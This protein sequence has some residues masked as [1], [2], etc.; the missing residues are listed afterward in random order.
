MQKTKPVST[1]VTL[2][3][4]WTQVTSLLL[5]LNVFNPPYRIIIITCIVKNF[6]LLFHPKHSEK[7]LSV[8]WLH[9]MVKHSTNIWCSV[10][11]FFNYW[12]LFYHGSYS[13]HIINEEGVLNV[14]EIAVCIL[15]KF[16]CCSKRWLFSRYL[17]CDHCWPHFKNYELLPHE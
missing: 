15:T 3:Y 9:T 1:Y 2:P 17:D 14:T 5:L 13:Y 12:N 8:S 6:I 10:R 11:P 16:Y 7:T 4:I